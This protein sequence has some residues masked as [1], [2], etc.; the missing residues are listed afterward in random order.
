MRVLIIGGTGLISTTTTQVLTARGDE[1]VLYN[2]GQSKFAAAPGAV[3]ITGDR[4][5]YPTFAR[6]AAELGR[7]DAVIDMVGYQPADADAVI[8]AF[9]GQTGQFIFCSTVDVYQKPASRYPV[10]ETEPYGGLNEYSRSKVIIE[11]KLRAAAEQGAFPLTIIRPAYT[12][13]EGR[14]PIHPIS[15]GKYIHRVRS[16]L[17]VVV[18][19]DGQSLWACNHQGDVGRCFAAAAGNPAAFGQ[20]YHVTGE[21]WLTWNQYHLQAAEALGAPAPDL[22]HIP[23]DFLARVGVTICAENFQFSNIFDN[24]AARRDLAYQYT[25]S[26]KEG[27]QRM[28]RWLDEHDC[29]EHSGQDE[30]EDRLV[31]GWRKACDRLAGELHT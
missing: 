12:Y 28:A 19:G 5:D 7:F 3:H 11:Q 23:S 17:P 10:R 18:Q 24:S 30:F 29:L 8:R 14:G 1:V 26:W 16:G 6:Q 21:E 22:V 4:T 13:G 2:R 15:W 9:A 31:S 20:C 27:V 25:V